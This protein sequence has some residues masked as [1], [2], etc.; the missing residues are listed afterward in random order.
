M[1]KL[2]ADLYLIPT[3]IGHLEDMT[4]RAINTLKKVDFIL[5]EDTRTSG[6]LLRHFEIDTPM[7]SYHMHNEHQ[8]VEKWVKR[9]K[10]GACI[11]LI[12]DAGTPGI[13]DPGFLLVRAAL[14]E[15]INVSALPGANAFVPALVMSGLPCNR[16]VFEGFL[17]LKKGRQKRLKA[18]KEIDKTMIFYESPHKILKTLRDFIVVFGENH[19]VAIIR[20]LSKIHEE[21]IKGSLLEVLHNLEQ[22]PKI[23]GEIVVILGERNDD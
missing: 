13:A 19:P 2:S 3:P 1:N 14:K 10:E 9:L 21:T 11:G 18:I 17:P 16:F 6:K 8:S 22:R 4:I 20:E 7:V 23:K 12:S 15:N 5:A